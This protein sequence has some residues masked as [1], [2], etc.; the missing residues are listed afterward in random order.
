M[1]IPWALA[2]EIKSRAKDLKLCSNSSENQST[3]EGK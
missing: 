2:Y 1:T 3:I